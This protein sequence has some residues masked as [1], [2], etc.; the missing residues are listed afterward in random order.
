NATIQGV[1]SFA[2]AMTMRRY[3]TIDR[4]PTSVLLG[5]VDSSIAGL[6]PMKGALYEAAHAC[7]ERKI[8]RGTKVSSAATLYPVL[9]RHPRLFWVSDDYGY[10]VSMSRK[11]PSGAMESALALIQEVYSGGTLY[12]DVDVVSAK[13]DIPE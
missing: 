6:R 7:G 9:L 1:L 12:L 2:A 11:Q 8:I 5:V 13:K 3:V 4:Q 10:M